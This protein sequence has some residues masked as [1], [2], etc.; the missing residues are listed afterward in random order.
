M[1]VWY[2]VRGTVAVL[3]LDNPPVNGLSHAVRLALAS[4]LERAL[5]DP[6][7]RS[8]AITGTGKVFSGGADIREFNTPAMLAQPSLLQ[9]IDAV[10]SAPKP[11]VAAIN[12]VC[13]GGGLELSLACH[14]RV[15]TADAS[16]ALPEVKLGLIP[17]AGS[18][19]LD[20]GA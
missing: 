5:D 19:A 11:V 1:T 7:V 20:P 8:L 15:A 14:Y 6:L 16:M 12:G 2:E 17:G 9:L 13:L 10:E 18:G 3:Q 4:H